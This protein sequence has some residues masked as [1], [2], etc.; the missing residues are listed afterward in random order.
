LVLELAKIA[1]QSPSFLLEPATPLH[2]NRTNLAMAVEYKKRG[3][4]IGVGPMVVGGLT[5]PI[6]IAGTL[7][8]QNADV[9]ASLYILHLFGDSKGYG[10]SGGAHTVHPKE[11]LTSF[12]SPNQA[13]LVLAEKQMG[14][15]YNFPVY[16]S[17]GLSD[18]LWPDFQL[19]Y[20]KGFG[21]AFA[22]VAGLS[23][24]G[25][26]SHIGAEQGA[27]LE[28]MVLD[29]EWIS[30]MNYFLKGFEINAETI[31]LD[32]LPYIEENAE[33]LSSEHSIKYYRQSFW[34]SELF[35]VTTWDR[36]S[37]ENHEHIWQKARRR[38]DEILSRTM[39]L[40][41]VLDEDKLKEIDKIVKTAYVYAE[42]L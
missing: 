5:A 39:P 28:Q 42:N 4:R 22:A 18:A 24:I 11:A 37:R 34:D 40:D 9:L 17:I 26:Q 33:C 30:R 20:E 16:G 21:S 36:W 2:F 14:D 38:V 32:L 7:V 23:G 10:Y 6:T 41:P 25:N 19:G 1:G 15:R 8:W 31:A 12:G 27:N 13:L 35:C 29:N 3:Y